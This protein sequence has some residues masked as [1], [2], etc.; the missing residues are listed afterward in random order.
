MW[1]LIPI[2][3]RACREYQH[4]LPCSEEDTD[5]PTIR[6]GGLFRGTLINAVVEFI[7]YY[8]PALEVAGCLRIMVQVVSI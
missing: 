8:F 2:N 3:G 4:H 5:N 6:I 7:E 1:G